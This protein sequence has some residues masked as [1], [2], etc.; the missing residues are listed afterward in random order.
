MIAIIL[1]ALC[2]PAYSLLTV[3]TITLVI[4][5]FAQVRLSIPD[6][7]MTKQFPHGDMHYLVSLPAVGSR[8]VTNG[9][10]LRAIL[11]LLLRANI[12]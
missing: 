8:L 11:R 4:M 9:I 2:L 6:C 12:Q 1:K 5:G 7:S 3:I 10:T